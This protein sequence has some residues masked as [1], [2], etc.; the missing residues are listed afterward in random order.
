MPEH[1]IPHDQESEALSDT[2]IGKAKRTED[3]FRKTW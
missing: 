2:E 1:N 3:F